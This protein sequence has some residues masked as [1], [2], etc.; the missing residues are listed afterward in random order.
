M[1][2]SPMVYCREGVAKNMR[3]IA[4]KESVNGN[5]RKKDCRG[6]VS[7]SYRGVDGRE[8]I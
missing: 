6:G 5:G 8:G 1:K 3:K 4:V 7:E 2:S